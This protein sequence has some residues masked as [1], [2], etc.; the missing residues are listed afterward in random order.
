M[1]NSSRHG[2]KRVGGVDLVGGW[3]GEHGGR[4][5]DNN[6]GQLAPRRY[7]PPID[8]SKYR[9]IKGAEEGKAESSRYRT[10]LNSLLTLSQRRGPRSH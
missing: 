10:L 4:V 3:D 8:S 5:K 1:S 9:H 2:S 7:D 6:T